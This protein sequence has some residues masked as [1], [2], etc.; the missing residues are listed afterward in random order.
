MKLGQKHSWYLQVSLYCKAEIEPLRLVDIKKGD[1]FQV[2]TFFG[3]IL[4]DI[5]TF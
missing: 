3:S 2:I 4:F 5:S 1:Y